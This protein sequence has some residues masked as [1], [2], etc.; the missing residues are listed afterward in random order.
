MKQLILTGMLLLAFTA[1][2]QAITILDIIE[3]DHISVNQT[4]P[5]IEVPTLVIQSEPAETEQNETLPKNVTEQGILA[6][7]EAGKLTRKVCNS[8]V[9]N[10]FSRFCNRQFALQNISVREFDFINQRRSDWSLTKDFCDKRTTYE[11]N[12][13]CLN[14]LRKQEAACSEQVT[15]G[16]RIII[17]LGNQVMYGLKNCELKV[18]TR[19]TTGKNKTPTPTGKWKIYEARGPHW[20]QGEWFVTKAFYFY[21]GYA[22]HDAG[23]RVPPFWK[24]ENRGVYG[25]H[26][27]INTP[28]LPMDELWDEFTVGDWVE[29]YYT[30]PADKQAELDQKIQNRAPI[31]PEVNPD[32]AV[33]QN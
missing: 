4:K 18:Y 11:N 13:H 16:N 28:F 3:T 14:E 9:G 2:A 5:K 29:I 33:N 15:N 17:D 10:Q 27:C 31:D 23:W 7:K 8:L 25:S 1:P 6:L 30:L 22:I 21:G 19:V 26:G 20:M 12:Q 32:F 24:P